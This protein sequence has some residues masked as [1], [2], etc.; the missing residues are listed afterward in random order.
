ML[1]R[2]ALHSVPLREPE[3]LRAFRL[4]NKAS[5]EHTEMLEEILGSALDECR[6]LVEFLRT[7]AGLPVR[8]FAL[9]QRMAEES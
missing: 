9:F 6:I 3:K 2:S 4:I 1:F 5:L 7:H 8:S